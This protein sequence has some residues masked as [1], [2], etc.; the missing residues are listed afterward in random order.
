MIEEKM[1]RNT[2]NKKKIGIVVG[3]VALIVLCGI[4]IGFRSQ[5]ASVFSGGNNA[6]ERVYVESVASIN[7]TTTGTVSRFNGVVETQDVFEIKADSSR[8]ISEIHVSVGDVV[9]KEQ[10]LVTYDLSDLKLQVEQ[11]NLEVE[12]IKNDIANEKKEI[13]LLE[14]QMASL[15]AEE[16]FT[17]QAEIQNIRNSISQ[18]EYDLKSKQLEIDKVK[19]QIN[20]STI[21]SEVEGTVKSISEKG[22]DDMGNSLPLISILQ[23]G[24][25]RIKGS[26]DEQNVWSINEGDAVFIRSRVDDTQIWKGTITKIDT[27]NAEQNSNNDYGNEQVQASKYPFYVSIDSSEGLIL[28]QHVYIELGE[29]EEETKDGIWLYGFYIVQEEDRAYVWASN[30]KN[31][32]EKRTV[33]LGEYNADMDQY[34]ILSG[35]TEEDMIAWPMDGLYEGVTTVTNMEEENWNYEDHDT[36]DEFDVSDEY[37]ESLEGTEWY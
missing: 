5:I 34:E 22:M 12:S 15:P 14:Q 20:H 30:S 31:R 11:A 24:D 33:E 17:Y 6:E 23:E 4:G 18:K 3:S 27:E 29:E 25:Y 8:K 35:L 16:Q 26:I 32:L 10:V 2:M 13:E 21:K 28:G 1:R 7:G 19:T 37:D 36:N 9:E